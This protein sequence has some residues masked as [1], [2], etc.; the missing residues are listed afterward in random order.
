MIFQ[1]PDGQTVRIDQAFSRDGFNYPAEWLRQ[2][3][4]E[5]RE[6]WGLVELPEPTPPETPAPP[7]IPTVVTPR[8]ARLALLAAGKLTEVE[9]V[10]AAADPAIKITWEYALEIRRDDPLIAAM[11][12][13]IGLTEAELDALFVAAA[14]IP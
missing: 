9:A 6:A 11:A 1:F 4:P 5:A 10:I 13:G 3:T 12:G 2:M 7:T 14:Q 8:Q